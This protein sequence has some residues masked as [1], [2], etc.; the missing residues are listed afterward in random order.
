MNKKFVLAWIVVFV[1]WFLGSFVVHGVL[2]HRDYQQ[3]GNL[4]RSDGDQQQFFPLMILAHALMSGALVWI[5]SRGVEP[6]PWLAQGARFGLAVALLAIVP[7]YL[8]YFA[9][10]PL[11]GGL[12]ARQ[13]IFDGVLT[14]VLGVLVA[15][16]YRDAATS[17]A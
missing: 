12:V 7:I 14:V 11:P 16:L 1:A 3:L 2:L 15:W 4:F 5:Y 17:S 10:Q 8:I 13:I 6:K 9:V